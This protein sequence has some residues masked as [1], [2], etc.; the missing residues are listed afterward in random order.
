MMAKMR[1]Y[2]ELDES[3]YNVKSISKEDEARIVNK[4]ITIWRNTSDFWEPR[5]EAAADNWK[6]L[7]GHCFTDSELKRYEAEDKVPVEVPVILTKINALTG[8]QRSIR[9]DGAVTTEGGEDAMSAE[10]VNVIL[11]SIRQNNNLD[12]I[13]SDTFLDGIVS[14]F[15]TFVWIDEDLN[16][17][18]DKDFYIEKD[19]LGGTLPDINFT[20]TDMSDMTY[21]LR[22]RGLTKRQLKL[23]YPDA[24]DKIEKKCGKKND[25]T[26]YPSDS[27]HDSD[28]RSDLLLT[29]DDSSDYYEKTGKIAVCERLFFIEDRGDFFLDTETEDVQVVPPD[30]APERVQAHLAENQGIVELIQDVEI[31]KLWV[32][33]ITSDGILLENAPHNYQEGGFPCAM[34]VPMMFNN[35]IRGTVDYMKNSQ[36]MNSIGRTEFVHSLRFAH[37]KLMIVKEGTLTDPMRASVEKAKT[38]GVIERTAESDNEDIRFESDQGGNQGFVD[39]SAVAMDDVDVISGIHPAMMGVQESA[40]ESKVAMDRRIGQSQINQGLMIDNFGLFDVNL[41]R[42]ILKMLPYVLDYNAV[43]RYTDENDRTQEVEV[44]SPQGFGVDGS[45]SSWINRLDTAKY[46]YKQAQGDN[47][48]SGREQENKMFV[49]LVSESLRVIPQE[50]WVAFLQNVPNKHAQDFAAQIE[51]Q[52]AQQQEAI[53]NGLIP[54]ETQTKLN[55]NI[56][57]QD[58][59]L[60]NPII[61]DILKRNG[62][63][64]QNAEYQGGEQSVGEVKQNN[65]VVQ[66]Q[67]VEQ[68][69][70]MV[71]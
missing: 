65:D 42:V 67:G 25:E 30:W 48:V 56:D 57:G 10:D 47:S 13:R 69:V 24:K 45:P 38:G 21:L 66:N 68:D 11:K 36:K 29:Y 50:F 1:E 60:N 33:T 15:P 35:K 37:D 20:K 46:D 7:D 62:A 58:I 40:N 54:P 2:V 59:Q 26:S 17:Q 28:E 8:F 18:N 63:L 22:I 51:K 32:T 49:S 44:N 31:Q 14:G 52:E 39:L 61:F 12:Y 19:L 9:K 70:Q 64:P 53:N 27:S 3:K 41:H 16:N 43:R 4:A 23:Y 5:L 6:A 55:L 34:Y 71:K